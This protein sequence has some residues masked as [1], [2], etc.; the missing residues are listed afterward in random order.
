MFT[1]LACPLWDRKGERE[2]YAVKPGFYF[3]AEERENN[4][5]EDKL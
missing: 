2:H 4:N 1:Y 3:L 5:W